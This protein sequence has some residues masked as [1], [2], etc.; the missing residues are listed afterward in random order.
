MKSDNSHN[1]LGEAFLLY[2]VINL[3]LSPLIGVVNPNSV[4]SRRLFISTPFPILRNIPSIPVILPAEDFSV[5]RLPA[6]VACACD[7]EKS[8]V[9]TIF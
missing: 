6:L 2:E 5:G 8:D 9:S 4:N 1:R 3:Q 7:L